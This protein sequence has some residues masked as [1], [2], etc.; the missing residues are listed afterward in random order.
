[1]SRFHELNKRLKD[2]EQRLHSMDHSM[3]SVVQSEFKKKFR[4][5]L[6]SPIQYGVYRA[7]C[8]QTIDPLKQNRVQFYDPLWCDPETTVDQLPFANPISC[9]GGFDDCGVSWVPPAGSTLVVACE[10]GDRDAVYYLGTTWVR[11]RG[12]DGSECEGHPHNF[13]YPMEEYNCIWEGHRKGYL[14]GPND[15]SQVFPPWNTEN[16]NNFDSDTEKDF[17]EDEAAQ[18]RVTW[19]HIYGIKTP[20][21]HMI[22]M[23]DGNPRCERR[24]KRFEMSSSC[25][26]WLMM[27]DDHLR[28]CGEWAHTR[29]GPPEPPRYVLRCGERQ[30]VSLTGQGVGLESTS[31]PQPCT[32]AGG[33][34]CA[35]QGQD[36]SDCHDGDNYLDC[37][38]GKS[39]L[40]DSV[41][42]SSESILS[43]INKGSNPFYKH[44]NECRPYR[45]VGTP[46]N[47]CCS[48]PQSGIQICTL[49]GHTWVGDDSVNKPFG[50]PSW[51]RSM[52]AFSFGENNI[53]EGKTFWKEATGHLIEMSGHETES[54]VRD[55]D[56]YIKIL[57]ASGNRIELNDHT[58]PGGDAGEKRGIFL[59]STSRH[60]I[61]MTDETN[62]QKSPTRQDG[63]VP[64]NEAN[65]NKNYIRLRTGYGIQIEMNDSLTQKQET[66]FQFYQLFCPQYTAPYGPHIH[67]FQELETGGFVFLR[68]GGYYVRSI[69]LD[70]LDIV[71]DEDIIANKFTKVYGNFLIDVD[72][73]YFN[74]ASLHFF[75][76]E[77][78]IFL[79]AGRD[80]PGENEDGPC[81]FPVVVWDGLGLTISDRVFASASQDA[82]AVIPMFGWFPLTASSSGNLGPLGFVQP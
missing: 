37:P 21:K 8:V 12:P 69:A 45:G 6:Q 54:E 80:C 9:M 62:E 75:F 33:E 71:G 70:E 39:I 52:Q 3:L 66:Q 30:Q 25:G 59:E 56:N 16:Y 38:S 11:D 78:F 47:Q 53:Y 73:I 17:Y 76:A 22:K 74:H 4:V 19:P 13:N 44:S 18:K 36:K 46:L 28:P 41:A 49:S 31:G 57:T 65:S 26:N 34:Q 20:E 2:V 68:A 81:I 23:V 72:L 1:M 82:P 61:S 55:E 32:G 15:G 50:E 43:N 51:E 42:R 63:G 77:E 48:L 14:V 64:V 58:K 7:L 29:M 10:A 67:H 27:K 40:G 79:A 5:Q 24:Y 35:P 60:S